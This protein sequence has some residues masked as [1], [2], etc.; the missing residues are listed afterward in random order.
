VTLLLNLKLL[1]EERCL[2]PVAGQERGGWSFS[3]QGLGSEEKG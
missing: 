1:A 3:S 2:L